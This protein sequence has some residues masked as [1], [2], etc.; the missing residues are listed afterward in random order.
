MIWADD[1]LTGIA[2]DCGT[3]QRQ[4]ISKNE[5]THDQHH[6]D[7]THRPCKDVRSNYIQIS[8]ILVLVGDV[9]ARKV[10]DTSHL[11]IVGGLNEMNTFEGFV[12]NGA[13]ATARLGAP[14]N[15]F[16]FSIANRSLGRLQTN[17]YRREIEGIV[18][19]PKDKSHRQS[20]ETSANWIW[21]L[22]N[23][24][25]PS[26]LTVGGGRASSTAVVGSKLS[27]LRLF[28]E[29]TDVITDV[30]QLVSITICIVPDL[31]L[32]ETAIS[33]DAESKFP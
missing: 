12:W 32:Q 10:T 30:P 9:H 15:F 33:M 13:S 8:N 2:I 18:Q 4:I 25:D 5:Q 3:S 7:P 11:H 16:A 29:S 23:L 1:T 28:G 6:E 24:L 19:V 21:T 22:M 26:G 20:Y 27:L 17:E 31:N 14:R